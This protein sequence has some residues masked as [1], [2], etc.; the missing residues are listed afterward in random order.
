MIEACSGHGPSFDRVR[1]RCGEAIKKWIEDEEPPEASCVETVNPHGATVP[2][3]GRTTLPG[4]R[5]GQNEDGFY[6]LDAEDD[7][8]P[9][10]D[11]FVVDGGSGQVFG[12]YPPGTRIKYTEAKG[13]TPTARTIGSANGQAGAV[14][15][16][17][18]GQGDASVFAVDAAGNRSD[19]ASCLVPPPPK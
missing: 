16:H 15:A 17:I 3:A 13:A 10:P 11:L 5:G 1:F 2:P 14:D 18:T 19:L 8:D 6:L 4:A 12:P 7:A 9:A